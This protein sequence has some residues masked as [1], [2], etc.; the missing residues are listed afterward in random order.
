MKNVNVAHRPHQRVAA[1]ADRHTALLDRLVL[2][3]A[4]AHLVHLAR[5][6]AQGRDR[7]R[8]RLHD[9]DPGPCPPGAGAE[10][11]AEAEA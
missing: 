1:A 4:L 6:Q 9:R 10:A 11:E 5:F 7:V 2:V 8:T 3:P